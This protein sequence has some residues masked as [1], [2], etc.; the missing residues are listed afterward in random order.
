MNSA[1]S[2]M[3]IHLGPDPEVHIYRNLKFLKRSYPGDLLVSTDNIKLVEFCSKNKISCLKYYSKNSLTEAITKSTYD[4]NFRNGFWRHT[5]ERFFAFNDAHAHL[6]NSAM[7]HIESDVLLLENFPFGILAQD[8]IMWCEVGDTHDSAA[9][10]Y[11]PN[12]EC[13]TWFIAEATKILLSENRI[14]DMTLLNKIRLKYPDRVS[15]LPSLTNPRL[16]D[17]EYVATDPSALGMWLLG[18]DPRNL[19]GFTKRFE[20]WTEAFT[21]NY[22]IRLT[23]SKGSIFQNQ[24]NLRIRVVNLHNHAKN[25]WFFGF[26]NLAALKFFVWSSKYKL[27]GKFPSPRYFI[28][29][30]K[31]QQFAKFR[32]RHIKIIFA[33]LK[34]VFS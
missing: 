1:P 34:S 28:G 12:L 6:P 30:V 22:P 29:F 10:F 2:L 5:I 24:P 13:T 19:F 11:S 8:K 32:L 4:T 20:W 9:I 25:S 33:A 17:G 7:I 16:I 26:M 3:I 18:S 21:L 31:E 27:F 14:T 15:L 23:Y